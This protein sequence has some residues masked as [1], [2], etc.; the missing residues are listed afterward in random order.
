V[1]IGAE[2]GLPHPHEQ[3]GERWIAGEVAAQGQSVGEEPDQRLGLHP[4]AVGDRRTDREVV[5]VGE[6]QQ[7]SLE[8]G[9]QRH[10]QGRAVPAGEPL[11]VHPRREG[12]ALVSGAPARDRR[13]GA[14]RRQVELRAETREVFGP[15]AELG[16]ELVAGELLPLPGRKVG[17]LDGQLRERRGLIEGR[18]LLRQQADRPAV[19]D[20][21][22]QG[23]EQEVVPQI[24]TD[25]GGAEE[26]ALG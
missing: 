1:D 13:A 4:R 9:E 15:V 6:T 24:E 16:G 11:Q 23:D 18:E 2:G 7:Q 5:L 25:Q 10:E 12:Q 14:V 26:R 8:A 21:V 20:G 3:S 22:V 17:V 19:G